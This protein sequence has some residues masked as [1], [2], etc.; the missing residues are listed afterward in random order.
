MDIIGIK[1]ATGDHESSFKK[2]GAI[3]C[4][5]YQILEICY[6]SLWFIEKVNIRKLN[7]EEKFWMIEIR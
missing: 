1:P 3:P 6:K 7:K 5:N 4:D 2:V